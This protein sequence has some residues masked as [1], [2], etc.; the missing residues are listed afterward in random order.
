MN[1]GAAKRLVFLA[2]IL[3]IVCLLLNFLMVHYLPNNLYQ[4]VDKVDG[5]KE[6][7]DVA[8][9]G[10]SRGTYGL[11]QSA[12]SPGVLN[13]SFFGEPYFAYYLKLKRLID[14]NQLEKAIV[15]PLDY[16]AIGKH[17]YNMSFSNYLYF[18]EFRDVENIYGFTG[19]KSLR[20]YQQYLYYYFPIFN[21][22]S[23]REFALYSIYKF[24]GLWSQ[25]TQ[26]SKKLDDCLQLKLPEDGRHAWKN[27]GLLSDQERSEL[28]DKS[29]RKK[30]RNKPFQQR[31]LLTLKS[32]IQLAKENGLKVYGLKMPL[33]AEGSQFEKKYVDL[34]IIDAIDN[35]VLPHLDGY[36]DYTDIFNDKPQFFHDSDHLNLEGSKIFSEIVS[37]YLSK[38]LSLAKGEFNCRTQF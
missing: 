20:T 3:L 33:A 10:D 26:K 24:K 1:L 19:K 22:K 8:I 11:R 16:H 23:R 29:N 15:I 34:N 2:F 9:F 12:L 38:E 36:L 13:Y 35:Q 25:S 21:E 27:W 32:T 4:Q 18:S 37:N 28:A 14:R 30:L 17:R 5:S 7:W 31:L 6:K